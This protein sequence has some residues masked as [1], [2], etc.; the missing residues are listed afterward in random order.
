V[1]RRVD[2]RRREATNYRYRRARSPEHSALTRRLRAHQA[3]SEA[4]A[5]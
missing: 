4:W 1:A 3:I 5:A 2:L